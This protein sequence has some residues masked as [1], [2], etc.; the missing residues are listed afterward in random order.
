MKPI[1]PR[2]FGWSSGKTPLPRNVVAT[3]RFRRSEKRTSGSMASSRATPGPA[4]TTGPARRIQQLLRP[5]DLRL[6]GRGIDRVVAPEWP[7]F[8]LLLRH[9][10]GQDQER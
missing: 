10:L 7:A 2:A 3:G 8:G 5:S 4:R 1:V 9:I 6:R